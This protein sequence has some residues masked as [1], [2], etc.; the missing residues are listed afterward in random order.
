MSRACG[1]SAVNDKKMKDHVGRILH[2]EFVILICY[3]FLTVIEGQKYQ[4][5]NFGSFRRFTDIIHSHSLLHCTCGC[6]Y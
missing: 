1:Y 4:N 6:V 3:Y 2:T 5:F